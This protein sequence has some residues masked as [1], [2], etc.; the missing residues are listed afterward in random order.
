MKDENTHYWLID[1]KEKMGNMDGYDLS[2]ALTKV[3][4]KGIENG[5]N[6]LDKWEIKFIDKN[7]LIEQY[8]ED[9]PRT[10][11]GLETSKLRILLESLTNHRFDLFM[12]WDT[13]EMERRYND[14]KIENEM[15]EER[16]KT[17]FPETCDFCGSPN[18]TY[19]DEAFS[20]CEN[21]Y[22]QI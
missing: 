14:D 8:F 3:L 22:D 11:R 6:G 4:I 7:I 20:L 1:F 13:E 18:V 15:L 5:K 12:K 16:L 21:C 17:A 10:I 2:S 9:I 19:R